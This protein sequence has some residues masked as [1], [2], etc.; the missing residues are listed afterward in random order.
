MIQRNAPARDFF[1]S[2]YGLHE[3]GF[4]S[5]LL[6]HPSPGPWSLIGGEYPQDVGGSP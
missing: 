5:L 6:G 2:T 4:K 1:E 3:T